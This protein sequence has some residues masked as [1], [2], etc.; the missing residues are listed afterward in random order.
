MKPDIERGRRFL[1]T[2]GAPNRLLVGVTGAH[3][4]GFP[5]PD[6]DLDLKGIHVAPTAAIVSL[7]PPP[8]A[9]DFLGI[10]EGLEI[11]YTSQELAAAVRLLVRGNGNVLE[12]VLSPFQLIES[13]EQKNFQR[14]AQESVSKKFFHHYRGFFGR[15]KADWE[16]APEKTV[17]GLLYAYRSALTGIHLLRTGECVGDV[18]A[19]APLYGFERVPHLVEQKGSGTEHG[20]MVDGGEFEGDLTRLEQL[21]EQ[22]HAESSLPDEPANHDTLGEFLVA[23]RRKHFD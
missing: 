18:T 9:I 8:D 14:L 12:R 1:E 11:D 19:L 2:S 7:A 3:Y 10:F 5:S 4:Y 6:S 21:L 20:S 22:A 16:K 17:K 13:V 23:L 15:M